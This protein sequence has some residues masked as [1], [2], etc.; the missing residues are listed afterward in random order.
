M[1][2]VEAAISSHPHE[3]NI[4]DKSQILFALDADVVQECQDQNES[5]AEMNGADIIGQQICLSPNVSS[6]EEN[7]QS[8]FGDHEFRSSK[9]FSS[10]K[11]GIVIDGECECLSPKDTSVD[12]HG[13]DT[14]GEHKDQISE[15][16]CVDRE[17]MDIIDGKLEYQSPD[18]APVDRSGSC[19]SVKDET[20][21]YVVPELGMEF[22]SEDRAYMCYNR[23]AA[24]EGFSIR[25]DFVNKSRINGLVISRRYTC[26]K[27]GYRP[28]KRDAN[29][30]KPRKDTRT[31]CLAHLT[32]AR[33]PNGK[34]CVAHFETKHNHEL[35]TPITAHLLPSQRRITFAEAVE[36]E[37][38]NNSAT[39]GVPKLGMGFV[40]E[41][42][43]Y[44]F[45]NAYAGQVGFSVRKDYVNR[46]KIDGAVASRRFTCFREG[47][48]QRDKRDLNV[49]RPRKETRI[50]CLAQLI[51]ARQPDGK[52]RITHFEEN[53]NHELVP[54]CRVR[55]LRSQKRSASEASA[56]NSSNTL[57]KSAPESICKPAGDQ[58]NFDYHPID[59][60]SKLLCKRKR[61]MRQG[62]AE[63]ILQYFQDKQLKDSSFFYA[64]QV[65]AEDEITNVFWADAKMLVDYGD[66]GDVVCFDTTY[67]LDKYCRPF[68]PFIGVNHHKQMVI[69]GAALLYDETVES[70]EWLFRTFIETMS[71]KK[72]KTILTDQHAIMSEAINSVIPETHQHLCVWHV[73]QNALKHLSKVIMGSD[74]FANDLGSCMFHHDEEEDFINAWKAMLDT[75]DLSENEWLHDIFKER[76]KWAIPYQR[77][78]FCADMINAQ[79][80]ESFTTN[81]RKYLKSDLDVLKFFKQFGKVVND[82]RYKE[83]EANYDMSQH[84]P[85]LMGDVILL[86]QARNIYTPKNFELFQQ[87]YENSLNAVVN[88]CTDRGSL[89]EYKVSIYGQQRE[90]V[91]IFNSSEDSVVCNC[92][93]FQFIG[94][95]CSHALKVLD[96]R[97]IK[98]IPTQYILKR[99]TKDARV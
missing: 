97:N 76:E 56:A 85:R 20:D 65:D 36:A 4:E 73:Y 32:I 63:S 1:D 50:G 45:Y 86:K 43:A 24:L 17:G 13:M 27:Q 2:T 44:E 99:W 14:D 62:E 61:E 3:E 41:D 57:S 58:G 70:F 47:F 34:Y 66:F 30:K 40:S 74:S 67:R 98:V 95:L 79:L 54:A 23:Y 92:K 22:E 33:Q 6:A 12:K 15:V 93:K 26:H 9:G 90:Y 78:F 42:H 18:V 31:G 10:N 81:L 91:V 11:N 84:M 35:A 72:P 25:K 71:G 82:W 5:S 37:L 55:M 53:H 48:R 83:L 16:F 69:F 64:V 39:D 59:Y 19:H 46:S 96:Y 7:G 68:A 75:Y 89:F 52:Y 8:I 94:V 60:N 87:E 49:K 80:S 28:T 88:Q 21:I 77:H 38:A 51:I 29:V